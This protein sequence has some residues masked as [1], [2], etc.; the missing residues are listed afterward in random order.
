MA[1]WAQPLEPAADLVQQ[2]RSAGKHALGPQSVAQRR[3]TL[4]IDG[5]VLMVDAHAVIP[6]RIDE[7]DMGSAR[8]HL[9]DPGER[10]VVAGENLSR[11]PRR[12]HEACPGCLGE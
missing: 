8:Q 6:L 4:V 2:G 5:S 1:T 3:R 9:G 7:P 12:C 11:V 10:R